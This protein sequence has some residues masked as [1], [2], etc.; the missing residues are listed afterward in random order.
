[1]VINQANLWFVPF[2]MHAFALCPQFCCLL[3]PIASVCT[4]NPWFV[5]LMLMAID[6]CAF[7]CIPHFMSQNLH[8]FTQ[9]ATQNFVQRMLF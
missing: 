7:N 6:P 2:D 4:K 8:L 5:P 9:V 1:M 3:K